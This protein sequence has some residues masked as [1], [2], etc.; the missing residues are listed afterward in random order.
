M[1]VRSAC[2][3]I[4]QYVHMLYHMV[5]GVIDDACT[6]VLWTGCAACT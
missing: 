3:K 5:L 2:I 6:L 1:V 4:I